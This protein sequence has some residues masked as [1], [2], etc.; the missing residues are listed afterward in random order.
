[1]KDIS[2]SK[3]FTYKLNTYFLYAPKRFNSLQ[4]IN[5]DLG[6]LISKLTIDIL[7]FKLTNIIPNVNQLMMTNTTKMT[8]TNTSTK[9]RYFE[10]KGY[11]INK[12]L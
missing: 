1:M 10:G 4:M 11:F 6:L 7:I 3:N 5:I 12:D 8:N 9:I 2:H